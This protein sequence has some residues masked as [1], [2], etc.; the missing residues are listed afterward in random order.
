M[1]SFRKPSTWTEVA[2]G[3]HVGRTEPHAVTP[4]V[5][6]KLIL[7]GLASGWQPAE[8]RLGTFFMSGE[9]LVERLPNPS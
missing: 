6:R 4:A 9:A 8:F 2:P 7:A 3:R 5:L 1:S